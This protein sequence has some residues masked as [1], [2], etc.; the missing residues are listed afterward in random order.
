MVQVKLSRSASWSTEYSADARTSSSRERGHARSAAAFGYVNNSKNIRAELGHASIFSAVPVRFS[1][2][3]GAGG[4]LASRMA[5]KRRRFSV[6]RRWTGVFPCFAFRSR[7]DR[8]VLSCQHS[9]A[10]VPPS[11]AQAVLAWR[12]RER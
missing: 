2:D 9:S 4:S 1:V 7:G 5:A 12:G 3:G 6:C 10:A 8:Y 11:S